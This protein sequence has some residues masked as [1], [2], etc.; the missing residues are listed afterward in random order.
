MRETRQDLGKLIRER[1]VTN[2]L[3][4][5]ELA[6]RIQVS[7]ATVSTWE[8]GRFQPDRQQL[9]L[10]EKVLGEITDSEA[11]DIGLPPLSAWLSRAMERRKMTAPEVAA[12]AGVSVPAVYNL[13]NGR[14][15]NPREKTRTSIEKVLGE[16]WEPSEEPAE[17]GNATGLG[18][19]VDFDPHDQTDI[20]TKPG[21]YVFYDLSQRPVYIGQAND[22]SRR[23]KEHNDQ[24]WFKPPIVETASYVEVTDKTLRDQLE[25]V[26]I[27]FLKKNAIINRRKTARE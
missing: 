19:L 13:L 21:V 20:P 11:P 15:E 27:Q 22:I 16:R 18:R 1:R 9:R 5:R 6:D 4:Q 14:V 8:V 10:L 7:Q 2:G 24:F 3:T 23:V 12:K 17:S 26:L 25:T